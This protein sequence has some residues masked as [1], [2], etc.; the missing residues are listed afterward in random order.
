MSKK[1]YRNQ[2]HQIESASLPIASALDTEQPI[3]VS[4]FHC[5]S[6]HLLCS[7]IA[8]PVLGLH[9]SDQKTATISHPHPNLPHR[10]S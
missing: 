3:Q 5:P 9:H 8:Y 1:S 2:S 6:N 10:G 4:L 7:A